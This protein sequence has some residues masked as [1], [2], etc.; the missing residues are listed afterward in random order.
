LIRFK[1]IKSIV[2]TQHAL[3]HNSA[4][5]V[6]LLLWLSLPLIGLF[7]G[8]SLFNPTLPHWTGP[9][10]I[11]LFL[12]AGIYW[13]EL[14]TQRFPKLIQWALGFFVFLVIGFVGL[15][16]VFPFQLGSKS[17]ENLGEYNPI[18]DVTGWRQFSAEFKTLAQQDEKNAIMHPKSPIIV[19]KWF[20]AGHI[21]FYTARPI[22]KQVIAIGAIEDVHKFAWL[23]QDQPN[24][25]LGQDA[26]FIQPSN[27]PYDPTN[28]ILPY[29]EKMGKTDTIQIQ[30]RGVVLRNFYIYRFKNCQKI[31]AP[32]LPKK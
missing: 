27:L 23:N 21:L 19:S 22:Q 30:A 25:Q 6:A 31:P 4:P 7:W 16:H 11:A 9:G 10:F 12:L 20:P 3:D 24:L 29:F 26:Y 17:Q 15:V 2:Q 28:L 8:I 14:S 32:I 13:S 5:I 18:N 1:K